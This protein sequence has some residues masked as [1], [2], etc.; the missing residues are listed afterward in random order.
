MLACGD[1]RH[2]EDILIWRGELAWP[3]PPRVGDRIRVP[4]PAAGLPPG[5]DVLRVR[6]VIFELDGTV[7][8]VMDPAGA[9]LTQRL[10]F[11]YE[12]HPVG[13]SL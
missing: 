11:G 2:P 8:L 9:E 3:S 1:P 4:G 12:W 6:E 13:E 7:Y 5:N 10:R